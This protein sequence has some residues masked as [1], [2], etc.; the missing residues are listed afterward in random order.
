[1]REQIRPTLPPGPSVRLLE[2]CQF[3]VVSTVIGMLSEP[4]P[5]GIA[6]LRYARDLVVRICEVIDERSIEHMP[7][8]APANLWHTMGV[9][10]LASRLE[11][12][13]ARELLDAGGGAA[14]HAITIDIE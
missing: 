9:D 6:N 13:V 7:F 14:T 1:M 10:A 2:L 5:H 12:E 11:S 8:T 3:L 4:T